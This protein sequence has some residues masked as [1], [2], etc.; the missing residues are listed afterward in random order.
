MN[1]AHIHLL[2]NHLPVIG[3]VVA[4]ALLAWALLRRNADLTRVSFAMF[5]VF[6]VFAV[7]VY[8][9]GEPAEELVEH[10][11]GVSHDMIEAHEEAAFAATLLLGALGTVASGGLFVFRRAAAIPLSFAAGVLALSL[12][13]AGAMAW[14][15]NLGGQVRHSEI[16]AD[17]AAS[18]EY[19]AGAPP[20]QLEDD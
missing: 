11:P 7:V 16:R 10:L 8:L 17:A 12:I 20:Y 4:I 19:P 13:P 15:A 14:T 6:A 18:A 3:T 9:T 2:L 5:G 1:T